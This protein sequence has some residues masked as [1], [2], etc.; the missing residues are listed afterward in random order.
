MLTAHG[1][2]TIGFI[3]GYAPH[4]QGEDTQNK[5]LSALRSMGVNTDAMTLPTSISGL[6]ASYKPGKR[7]NPYFQSRRGSSTDYD[8]AAGYES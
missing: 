8:A 3:K 2:S 4:M 7:W 6:T 5:L 1:Y